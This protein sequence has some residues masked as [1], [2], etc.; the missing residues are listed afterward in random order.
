[1]ECSYE[2]LS[3]MDRGNDSEVL[4]TALGWLNNGSPVTLVTVA[5][6]WGSAPR[7]PGALMAIHPDGCFTGSVS[8]G[9]VEDELVQKVLRGEL[10]N[11]LPM[12]L[13]YGVTRRQVQRVGLPCGGRLSLV[14]EYIKTPAQLSTLWRRIAAREVVTRHLCL[15]TGE[16]SLGRASGDIDFRF[17][18]ASLVKVFG[19]HWRLLIIGAGELG[20]RVAQL[21]LTL[22]YGVTLCDPRPEY[23]AGWQVEGTEFIARAPEDAVREFHPDARTAVLALSHTPALD[24]AALAVAL[25]SEAFYV[26]ALGSVN[27]QQ[28]RCRRLQK[29]GVTSA[30]L[31]RLHGPVGLDIGSRTPAEIAIAIIGALV[32]ER[33]ASRRPATL[34]QSAHG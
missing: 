33:S 9:C 10:E 12:L 15:A 20:R 5:K 4:S 24:D 13:E 32:A 26:G 16:A 14:A 8:G 29:L 7:R 25:Q 19:P 6:T 28:A 17:D 3:L 31:A 21:A 1:M 23:A 2:R 27:N 30:A 11:Q 18:G 34:S 22:D